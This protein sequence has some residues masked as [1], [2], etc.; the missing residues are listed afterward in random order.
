M[1]VSVVEKVLGDGLDPQSHLS[2]IDR[3]IAEVEAQAGASEVR[4]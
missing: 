3:T 2:L 4:T 1:A